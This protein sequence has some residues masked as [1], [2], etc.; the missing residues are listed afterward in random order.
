MKWWALCRPHIQMYFLPLMMLWINSNFSD[1]MQKHGY[2][3]CFYHWNQ[4]V[5]ILTTFLSLA[6]PEVVILTSSGATSDEKVVNMTTFC[7]QWQ[8]WMQAKIYLGYILLTDMLQHVTLQVIFSNVF[9]RVLLGDLKI[10]MKILDFLIR[11]NWSMFLGV[12]VMVSQL[13]FR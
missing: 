13:W 10:Y 11:F 2:L 7:F 5:V 9:Y 3:W 6:A 4:K 12:W 1:N 8:Q